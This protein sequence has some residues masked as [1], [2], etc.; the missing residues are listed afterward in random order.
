MLKFVVQIGHVSV[1]LLMIPMPET[2][3]WLVLH[4]HKEQVKVAMF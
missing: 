4:G 3:P 2:P 1:V